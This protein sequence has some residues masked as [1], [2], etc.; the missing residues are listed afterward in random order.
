MNTIGEEDEGHTLSIGADIQCTDGTCAK[1]EKL[2]VNPETE[3]VEGLIV[4]RGFLKKDRRV[5]PLTLVGDSGP[6]EIHITIHSDELDE[7]P[8]YEVKV[9]EEPAEGWGGGGGQGASPGG[10][11]APGRAASSPPTVRKRIH[12]GITSEQRAIKKGTPVVDI[13]D[14]VGTFDHVLVNDETGEITHVIVRTRGL[15]PN[16]HAVPADCIQ[17]VD[18]Q[19]VSLD[20][21][22]DELSSFPAYEPD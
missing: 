2:A 18:D 12:Q 8:A 4:R 5:L 15:V 7:Y 11:G 22:G 13:T 3:K 19:R 14:K 21:G 16:Y 6:D 17:H 1:L 9:F 10:L 20:L